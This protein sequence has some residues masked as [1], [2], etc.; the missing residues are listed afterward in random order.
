M[1]N[2]I[3]ISRDNQIEPSITVEY[4]KSRR[5]IGVVYFVSVLIIMVYGYKKLDV[6]YPHDDGFKYVMLCFYIFAFIALLESFIRLLGTRLSINGNKVNIK[7]AFVYSREYPITEINKCVV[8]KNCKLRWGKYSQ[9]CT[10]YNKI[11]LDFGDFKMS[12]A[13]RV[14]CNCDKLVEYLEKLDKVEYVEQ[15][16]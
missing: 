5:R 6:M 4:M 2:D 11:E 8:Y 16:K 7:K 13:D 9:P 10:Y 3:I 12:F 14:Y 1:D 15:S